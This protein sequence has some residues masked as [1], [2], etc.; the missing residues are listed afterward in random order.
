M[1]FSPLPTDEIDISPHLTDRITYFFNI[2]KHPKVRSEFRERP[3]ISNPISYNPLI[4][5]GLK[6][7]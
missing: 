6:L 5:L 3:Y 4:A 7:G 1:V 2:L